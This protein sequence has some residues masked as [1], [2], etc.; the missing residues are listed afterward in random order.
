MSIKLLPIAGRDVVIGRTSDRRHA[1]GSLQ[2][3]EGLPWTV[4]L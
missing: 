4:Q 2:R 3:P 1:I